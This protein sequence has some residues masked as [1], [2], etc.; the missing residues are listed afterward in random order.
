[1][2]SSGEIGDLAT[3]LAAAQAEFPAV[4]KSGEN[5]Q[6]RYRYADLDDYLSTVRPVLAR[7]GLCLSG[8]V[9]EAVQ[10]APRET[11]RGGTMLQV[12][13]R[14]TLR[15]LHTSGQWIEA[16]AYGDGEDGN[17]KSI[18]KA[19]TG[20]R[21]YAVASLLGLATTDD[22]EEDAAPE[23]VPELATDEQRAALRRYWSEETAL[24]DE[25]RKSAAQMADNPTLRAAVAE[26]ALERLATIAAAAR[27]KE[28]A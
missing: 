23:P 9:A 16:A 18:Y 14:V 20:A 17:D 2:L 1:M 10:L 11:A 27:K 26:R 6:Q 22:P 5:T 24:S 4:R 13:V 21:K 3:A 7:H 28:G 12:R 15:L 19:T 25:V 8:G